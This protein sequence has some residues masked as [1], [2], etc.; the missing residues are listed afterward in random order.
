M[1]NDQKRQKEEFVEKLLAVQQ[2]RHNKHLFKNEEQEIA[3]Q[4]GLSDADWQAVQK[5]YKAYLLRG[6]VKFVFK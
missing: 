4:I 5:T 1:N 2:K 6:K 3:A